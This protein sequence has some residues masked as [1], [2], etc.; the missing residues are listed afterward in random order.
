MKIK[1][2]HVT[3][4]TLVRYVYLTGVLLEAG[5]RGIKVPLDPDANQDIDMGY[6]NAII[7]KLVEVAPDEFE[8]KEEN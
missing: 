2:K 6:F 5:K 8:I 3:G 4:G 7:D 1:L